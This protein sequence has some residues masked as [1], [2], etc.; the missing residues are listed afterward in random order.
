M[1][2]PWTFV[3]LCVYLGCSVELV[4]VDNDDWNNKDD[5][6]DDELSSV[7]LGTKTGYILRSM[8]FHYSLHRRY[9]K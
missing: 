2:I 9:L 7:I 5:D 6:D 3:S 1:F 8:C 4:T